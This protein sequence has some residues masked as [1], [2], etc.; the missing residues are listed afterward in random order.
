MKI[1]KQL[2]GKTRL[3]M[4]EEE[5]INLGMCAGWGHLLKEDTSKE[6]VSKEL[7]SLEIDEEL[8]GFA[9]IH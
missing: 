5:W 6:L 7:V 9:E 3:K 4:S 2:N 1:V 8:F